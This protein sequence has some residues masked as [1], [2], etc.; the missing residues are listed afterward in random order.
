MRIAN[1]NTKSF[2]MRPPDC[3]PKREATSRKSD[4]APLLTDARRTSNRNAAG[5]AR[6]RG[7][8]SQ[9]RDRI[10]KASV[11]RP[12]TAPEKRRGED[13]AASLVLGTRR[14]EESLRIETAETAGYA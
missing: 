9:A 2:F 6:S 4:P 3:S 12:L 5:V 1:R 8:T 14:N 7:E 10:A 11:I 13:R